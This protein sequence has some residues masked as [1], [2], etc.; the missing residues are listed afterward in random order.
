MSDEKHKCTGC[1]A[2]GDIPEGKHGIHSF[3]KMSKEELQI[4]NDKA[5]EVCKNLMKLGHEEIEKIEGIG[6]GARIQ[7][8]VSTWASLLGKSLSY[9]YGDKDKS[10]RALAHV[11]D[12]LDSYID[13]SAVTGDSEDTNYS[14]E[15]LH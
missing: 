1:G 5:P 13:I 4:L 7:L 8:M 14:G 10:S 15:I 11:L 6:D 2:C 9:F 12:I 3:M